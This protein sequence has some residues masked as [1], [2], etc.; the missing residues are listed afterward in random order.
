MHNP[1]ATDLPGNSG[2]IDPDHYAKLSPEP[3]DVIE[4]WGLGFHSANAVKYIARAGRKS[5]E[6]ERRDLIK[7]ANYLYRAATG[8][9]LPRELVDKA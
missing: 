2:V 7:A 8:R 5:E 9:W 4:A 1:D 6:S 3:I